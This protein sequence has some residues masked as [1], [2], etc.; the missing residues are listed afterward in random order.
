MNETPIQVLDISLLLDQLIR[1]INE[2]EDSHERETAI[3]DVIVTLSRFLSKGVNEAIGRLEVCKFAL[4]C[5][6]GNEFLRKIIQ[7]E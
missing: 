6:H 7:S 3:R 4:L 1:K 5:I 2:I